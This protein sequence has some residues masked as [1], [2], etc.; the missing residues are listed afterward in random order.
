VHATASFPPELE[1]ASS[2][3]HFAE[4][5][6]DEWALVSVREEVRLL[7]SELVVNAVLHAGTAAD[8]SLRYDGACL[9]VEVSDGSPDQPSPRDYEPSAPTGRGLLILDHLVERWGVDTHA[10]GKTVWF[11]MATGAAGEVTEAARR[12]STGS[13]APGHGLPWTESA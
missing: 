12:S 8:V 3:R 2:A 13:R 1:S 6:L 10:E 9:R 5:V 4:G 7:V 11:E